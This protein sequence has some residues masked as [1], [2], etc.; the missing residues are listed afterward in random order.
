MVAGSGC[1][2]L[3]ERVMQAFAI[4]NIM[5]LTNAPSFQDR[6]CLVSGPDSEEGFGSLIVQFKAISSTKKHA[7]SLSHPHIAFQ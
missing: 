2:F 5:I 4:S 6:I 3:L 7:L 1:E